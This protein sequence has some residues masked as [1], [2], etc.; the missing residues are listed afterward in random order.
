MIHFANRGMTADEVWQRIELFVPTINKAIHFVSFSFEEDGERTRSNY[1][2]AG[3]K[4]KFKE[5][6]AVCWERLKTLA[7]KYPETKHN[8]LEIY[9]ETYCDYYKEHQP[10]HRQSV[11]LTD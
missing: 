1:I 9:T 7:D 6:F 3:D 10:F 11:E 2:C 8:R 5:R 4:D